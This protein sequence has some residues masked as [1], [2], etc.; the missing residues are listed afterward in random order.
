MT[1]IKRIYAD[2]ASPAAKFFSHE[3]T[4]AQRHLNR[5]WFLSVLVPSWLTFSHLAEGGIKIRVNRFICAISAAIIV[6]LVL[7]ETLLIGDCFG[8]FVLGQPSAGLGASSRGAATEGCPYGGHSSSPP[9]RRR[10]TC[11]D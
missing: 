4:K 2:F 11:W 6:A 9:I 3:G 8:A 7:D 1:Q 5:K 10:V